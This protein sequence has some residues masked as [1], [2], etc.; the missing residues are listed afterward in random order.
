MF[1]D[2][3][4]NISNLVYCKLQQWVTI[5]GEFQFSSNFT[6]LTTSAMSVKYS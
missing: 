2:Y 1:I 6:V 5:N 3:V 4:L